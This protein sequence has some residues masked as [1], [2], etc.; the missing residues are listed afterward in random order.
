MSGGRGRTCAHHRPRP[1]VRRRGELP[2]G[3]RWARAAAA[4]PRTSR[5]PTADDHAALAVGR[6]ASA[7]KALMRGREAVLGTYTPGPPAPKSW[8]T[9]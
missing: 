5:T 1:G 2:A 3:S 4:I 7:T 8:P 6:E 9:L